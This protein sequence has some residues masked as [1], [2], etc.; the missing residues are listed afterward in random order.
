MKITLLKYKT[1]D[2]EEKVNTIH[3]L[4]DVSGNIIGEH[5]VEEYIDIKI[6]KYE[7]ETD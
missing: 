5:K 4:Y 1:V 3:K 7:N 6:E 2:I